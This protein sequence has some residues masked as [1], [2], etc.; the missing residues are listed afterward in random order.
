MMSRAQWEEGHGGE[1]GHGEVRVTVNGLN[2]ITPN[3][4]KK[5]LR[6]SFRGWCN[7]SRAA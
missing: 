6:W 3:R 1:E 4:L 5:Q 7:I 2:E